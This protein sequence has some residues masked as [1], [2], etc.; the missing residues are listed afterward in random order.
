MRKGIV[1]GCSLAVVV[2]ICVSFTGVVGKELEIEKKT[3]DV[4]G[5]KGQYRVFGF[6]PRIVRG[7]LYC[8]WVFP[9]IGACLNYWAFE[10]YAFIFRIK[11]YSTEQPEYYSNYLPEPVMNSIL[12]ALNLI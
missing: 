6:L 10:G 1:V 7:D 11:G 5:E 3:S 9:G 12:K 2:L 4:F 8:Y